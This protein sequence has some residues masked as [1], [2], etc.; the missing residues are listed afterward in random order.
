MI[1]SEHGYIAG[2]AIIIKVKDGQLT[3][4]KEE[5]GKEKGRR[6]N[7]RASVVRENIKVESEPNPY[8]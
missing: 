6:K 4:Y 3:E 5:D 1:V 2:Y 8:G 7:Q